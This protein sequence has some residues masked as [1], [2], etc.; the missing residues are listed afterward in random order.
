MNHRYA[1]LSADWSTVVATLDVPAST[2]CPRYVAEEHWLDQI[3]QGC[4]V[5][6]SL[7]V[8]KHDIAKAEARIAARA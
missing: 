3:K 1:L 6:S 8:N 2:W 5:V 7:D 4:V